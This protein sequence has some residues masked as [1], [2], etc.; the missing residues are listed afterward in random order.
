M[1]SPPDLEGLDDSLRPLVAEA[2]A[3]DPAARPSAAELL[4][5]AEVRRTGTR[6]LPARRRRSWLLAP[7][8]AAVAVAVAVIGVVTAAGDHGTPSVP[9]VGV[10]STTPAG[11][12]AATRHAPVPRQRAARPTAAPHASTVRPSVVTT[13]P[14]NGKAKEKQKGKGQGSGKNGNGNGGSGQRGG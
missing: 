1:L 6:E 8:V 9:P 3:K 4:E 10:A 13:A 2:L 11:N 12:Q 5:P 14:A 7:A